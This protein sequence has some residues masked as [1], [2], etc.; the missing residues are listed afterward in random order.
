MA[1]KM[2]RIAFNLELAK[3]INS[4]EKEGRIVT[5]ENRE[6]FVNTWNSGQHPYTPI[7]GFLL[8]DNGATPV[9]FSWL[10]DGTYCDPCH[11]EHDLFL[12]VPDECQ[13]ILNLTSETFMKEVWHKPSEMP[14][15]CVDVLCI[16]TLGNPSIVVNFRRGFK[17]DKNCVR[18]AYVKELQ[19]QENG[20]QE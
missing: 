20:G 7:V 3:A 18:W 8:F 12:E 2:K 1:K 19:P 5:R 13:D 17:L 11:K 16:D 4:G 9:N 14:R 15:R 10:L 6:F